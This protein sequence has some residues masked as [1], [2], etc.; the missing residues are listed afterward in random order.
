MVRRIHVIYINIIFSVFIFMVVYMLLI[1]FINFTSV[2]TEGEIIYNYSEYYEYYTPSRF[3]GYNKHRGTDYE[4]KYKYVAK[5]KIYI[6]SRI[7]NVLIFPN[8]ILNNRMIKVYYN[9][10]FHGYSILFKCSLKHF[11]INFFP[12]VIVLLFI[13]ILFKKNK[14]REIKYVDLLKNYFRIEKNLNKKYVVK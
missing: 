3:E 12:P 13:M 8:S 1:I 11:I 7:S 14:V 5:D 2:E 10:F 9:Y 6:S 4:F